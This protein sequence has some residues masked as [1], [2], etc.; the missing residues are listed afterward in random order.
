[1][2]ILMTK[3][4]VKNLILGIK[5]LVLILLLTFA[6]SELYRL[7][8][9]YDFQNKMWLKDDD[10]SGNPLKVQTKRIL[11]DSNQNYSDEKFFYKIKQDL[12]GFYKGEGGKGG[13]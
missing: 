5:L 13:K 7:Y 11:I 1:M 4:F 3:R 9:Q 12:Q 10:P 2:F 8:H 6:L